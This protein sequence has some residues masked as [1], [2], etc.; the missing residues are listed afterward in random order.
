[1]SIK[2]TEWAYQQD[3]DGAA[4]KFVLVAL[5]D[6]ADEAGTCFPGQDLLARRTGQSVESVRRHLRWLEEQGYLQRVRRFDGRGYRTSDRFVLNLDHSPTGQSDRRSKRPEVNM[7]A[8]QSDP[9]LPV[10][11]T[12]PTGQSEGVTVREPSENRKNVRNGAKP[13]R[14][15]PAD[16]PRFDEF[17]D[18]YPRKRDKGKARPAWNKAVKKADPDTIIA[19]AKRYAATVDRSEGG[20]FIKYP[21]SWLN[22]EAWDDEPADQDTSPEQDMWTRL[23]EHPA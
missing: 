14:K 5:G 2:A 9:S 13:K 19:A 23:K 7:T 10:N 12:V 4:A 8:G 17:W 18:I 22:A 21:A 3:I 16:A 20:R 6:F 15:A 11:L 1:M